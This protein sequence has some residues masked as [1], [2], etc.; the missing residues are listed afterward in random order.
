ML[1]RTTIIEVAFV[2]IFIHEFYLSH[3]IEAAI[4]ECSCFSNSI[5]SHCGLITVPSCIFIDAMA[6]S[7][8]INEL[9][10]QSTLVL[11][12]HFAL[13][14]PFVIHE[15]SLIDISISEVV[16]AA[17]IS[18]VAFEVSF[19]VFTILILKYNQIK[20]NLPRS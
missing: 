1:A 19:I 11:K 18:F 6:I 9:R 15:F 2:L 8:I 10:N 13:S 3:V 16:S 7:L 17:A 14:N 12:Y 4:A 20:F 5:F